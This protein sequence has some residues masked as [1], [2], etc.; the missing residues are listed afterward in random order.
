MSKPIN[1][2]TPP[3]FLVG[4]ALEGDDLWII[5][6]RAPFVAARISTGGRLHLLPAS[7][8]N[9][10]PA[11]ELARLCR[12]MLWAIEASGPKNL[13]YVVDER[14]QAPEWLVLDDPHNVDSKWILQRGEVLW[15][16]NDSPVINESQ[17]II[18]TLIT[19]VAGFGKIGSAGDVRAVLSFYTQ[20]CAEEGRNS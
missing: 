18:G 5:H 9:E 2:I 20:Y 16:P 6:T 11:P 14:E 13:E 8:E 19:K 10:I 17:G 3:E 4:W 15:H 7:I 12:R 1:N